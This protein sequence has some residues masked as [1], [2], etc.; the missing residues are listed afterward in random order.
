MITQIVDTTKCIVGLN[1]RYDSYH[2]LDPIHNTCGVLSHIYAASSLSHSIHS[3]FATSS[4]TTTTTQF[5]KHPSH[6]FIRTALRRGSALRSTLLHRNPSHSSAIIRCGCA[7]RLQFA[8]SSA[9]ACCVRSLCVSGGVRVCVC[10][11]MRESECVVA[12]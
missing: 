3:R 7:C 5:T 4:Q 10:A 2:S 6:P 1:E 8:R 9:T 11:C 12:T